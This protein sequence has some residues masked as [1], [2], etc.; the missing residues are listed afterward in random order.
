MGVGN[1]VGKAGSTVGDKYLD[2][3]E[4]DGFTFTG[5]KSSKI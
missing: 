4:E 3:F 1:G 5:N 2:S